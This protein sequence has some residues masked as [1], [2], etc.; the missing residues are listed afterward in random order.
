MTGTGTYPTA[1]G[2]NTY[3]MYST[4]TSTTTDAVTPA[5]KDKISV[6]VKRSAPHIDNV[7]VSANPDFVDRIGG[8]AD[9]VRAGHPIAGF[10]N[11]FSTLVERIFPTRSG[12]TTTR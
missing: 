3:G 2:G 6:E 4:S 7:Y 12:T 9:Q 11:E 1:R 8:F 5:M 10:A